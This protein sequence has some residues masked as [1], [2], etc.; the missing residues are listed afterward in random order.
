MLLLTR[1]RWQPCNS[2]AT[3]YRMHSTHCM[4]STQIHTSP[5]GRGRPQGGPTPTQ[6][7]SQRPTPA[8]PSHP[9][10]HL[11]APPSAC[12]HLALGDLELRPGQRARLVKGHHRHLAGAQEQREVMA[13]RSS[14][15]CSGTQGGG[16]A[17]ALMGVLPS[18]AAERPAQP[19]Q[20]SRQCSP[21]RQGRSCPAWWRCF[22]TVKC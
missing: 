8:P 16:A 13:E 7:H 22:N 6:R 3:E 15:R 5:T 9:Y 4:H 19:M 1:R 21:V 10:P 17:A 12:P 20:S 2:P 14:R 11:K 18:A